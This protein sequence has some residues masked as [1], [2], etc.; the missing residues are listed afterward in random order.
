MI[1]VIKLK[2]K[3]AVYPERQYF[4]GEV[5]GNIVKVYTDY[6]DFVVYALN[7]VENYNGNLHYV[8]ERF[9]PPL[10]LNHYDIVDVEYARNKK[11]LYTHFRLKYYNK[12]KYD[13][14]MQK[15]YEEIMG[16]TKIYE[17]VEDFFKKDS[18][19]KFKTYDQLVEEGI[20]ASK[21]ERDSWYSGG[22]R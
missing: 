21:E 2:K 4:T 9:Q 17:P 7:T 1:K 14:Y 3:S 10:L 19:F 12:K 18:R 20:V 6:N 16:K 13:E 8:F 11:D 15:S 22:L 5:D